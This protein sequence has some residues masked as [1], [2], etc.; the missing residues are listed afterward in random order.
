MC[1]QRVA[2]VLLTCIYSCQLQVA[3]SHVLL[4]CCQRVANVL[5]TCIYSCQLQVAGSHVL[6]TCCQRV[7][8]VLL[9]CIYSCQLQ[10]AGSHGLSGDTES[11]L[12]FYF[13][14]A[15]LP[16]P[17]VPLKKKNFPATPAPPPLF[18]HTFFTP[19]IQRYRAMETDRRYF[20]FLFF[21]PFFLPEIKRYRDRW[22]KKKHTAHTHTH[23]HIHT[24]TTHNTHT[25]TTHT[26]THNTHTQHTHTTHTQRF[27]GVATYKI[28]YTFLNFVFKLFF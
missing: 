14:W 5:L 11:T 15:R 26:H 27:D 28:R 10:V 1:C 8:N 2:N 25:H 3:G 16:L 4:T 6:L 22:Q 17:A 21:P 18:P 7:A 9:T 13:F 23:T 24:H 12:R 19:E 20:Y